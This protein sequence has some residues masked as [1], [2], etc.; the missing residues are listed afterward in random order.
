MDCGHGS[1]QIP[2]TLVIFKNSG[3]F[4]SM[5]YMTGELPL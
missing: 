5:G 2:V 1:L 3:Y 4:L